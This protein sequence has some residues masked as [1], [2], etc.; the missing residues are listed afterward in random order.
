MSFGMKT[1]LDV[2]LQL[3]VDDGYY[4]RG[5]RINTFGPNFRVGA[6]FTGQH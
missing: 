2:V 5:H 6:C 1:A 4:S 3:L